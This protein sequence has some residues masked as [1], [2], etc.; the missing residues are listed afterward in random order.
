[1][2]HQLI[3][4]PIVLLLLAVAADVGF[5]VRSDPRMAWLRSLCIYAGAIG[6]ALASVSGMILSITASSYDETVLYVHLG[7]GLACTAA[8][9]GA[10]LATR[11][12]KA[13]VATVFAVFAA[14]LVAAAGVWGGYLG[15]PS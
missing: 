3:H 6:A 12:G 13:T 2:H 1:M 7:L 14:S 8:A 15:H 5:R 9:A 4:F 11:Y 10:A